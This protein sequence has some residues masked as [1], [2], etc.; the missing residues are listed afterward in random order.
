MVRI[1][2]VPALGRSR[3]GDLV[4]KLGLPSGSS[5]SSAAAAVRDHCGWQQGAA[6]VTGPGARYR[7]ID[8]H[9][10][11]PGQAANELEAEP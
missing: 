6:C 3:R 4:P 8:A 1:Q 7:P 11:R 5:F 2:S 9:R 10:L